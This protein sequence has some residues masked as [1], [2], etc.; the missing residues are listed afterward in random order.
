M[1]QQYGAQAVLGRLLYAGEIYRMTAAMNVYH[2]KTAKDTVENWA[3]WSQKNKSAADLLI[4]VEK[5]M[6]EQDV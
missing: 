6:A 4:V 2:A 1:I 3:E 5:I